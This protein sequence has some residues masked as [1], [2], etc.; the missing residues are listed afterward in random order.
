MSE[1]VWCHLALFFHFEP[2]ARFE[3]IN[4]EET[5]YAFK[6]AF[7]SSRTGNILWTWREKK[8]AELI[9]TEYNNQSQH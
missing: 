7:K 3:L 8:A 9:Y 6:K 4:A 5:V 2:R 1:W